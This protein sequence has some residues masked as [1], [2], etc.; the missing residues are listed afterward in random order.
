MLFRHWQLKKGRSNPKGLP[1]PP[2]PKGYPLIGN[3]LDLP[4][5]RAWLVYDEWSKIYGEPFVIKR[6]ILSNDWVLLGDMIYF[7]VLGQHYLVLSS[8][9]RITDLFEK[10]SSSYSDRPQTPMV[11]EL[12]VSDL[13]HLNDLF[14]YFA[15]YLQNEVGFQLRPSSIRRAVAKT[16]E[17]IPRVFPR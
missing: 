2:G 6:I 1:L 5:D 14:E 17:I 4:L 7:N 9:R 15:L 3:L 13:F 8:S 16:Q 10:R 12:Y 11:M